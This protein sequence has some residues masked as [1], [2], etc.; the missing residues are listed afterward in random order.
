MSHDGRVRAWNLA[1]KARENLKLEGHK[2]EIGDVAIR[3]DG[4]IIISGHGE[5]D[6]GEVQAWTPKLAKR[7]LAWRDIQIW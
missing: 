5:D 2:G 1:A 6:F 3:D 7:R 4:S